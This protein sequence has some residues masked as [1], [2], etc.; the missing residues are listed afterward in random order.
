MPSEAA[1]V[2]VKVA[3]SLAST[4]KVS[5][6]SAFAIARHA[7][8]DSGEISSADLQMA[9]GRLVYQVKML[10][11][12]KGASEVVVDAMSGEV[13]KDKKYGGLKAIIEHNDENRKLLDAKRDSAGTKKSP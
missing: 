8:A 7:A 11:K 4:V 10:L 6:D 1:H 12:N 2:N 13:L 3:P 9:S 5:G